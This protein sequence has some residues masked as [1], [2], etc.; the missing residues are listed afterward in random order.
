ML[1]GFGVLLFAGFAVFFTIDKVSLEK[2][3]G[4]KVSHIVL[5]IA[6]VLVIISVLLNVMHIPGNRELGLIAI[7]V[8]VTYLVFFRKTT[9][10]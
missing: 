9:D 8:F 10:G 4:A 6:M 2:N 7:V 1:F 3:R 5:A